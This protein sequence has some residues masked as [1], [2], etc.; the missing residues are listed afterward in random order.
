MQILETKKLSKNNLFL[1][2]LR[3]DLTYI[4]MKELLQAIERAKKMLKLD[5]PAEKVA[6]AM[7]LPLDM[8][9]TLA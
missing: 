7:E 3:N 6:E 4:E 1:K 5:I 8:V 2:S 9:K